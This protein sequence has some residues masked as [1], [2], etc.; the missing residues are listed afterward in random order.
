MYIFEIY[1]ERPLFENPYFDWRHLG[2]ESDMT[3]DQADILCILP[4]KWGEVGWKSNKKGELDLEAEG[5]KDGRGRRINLDYQLKCGIRKPRV[6]MDVELM[7]K[8]WYRAF[9]AMLLPILR[10]QPEKRATAEQV[11]QSE[12]M[13]GWGLPAPYDSQSSSNL[14]SKTEEVSKIG[15]LLAL[16]NNSRMWCG[17]TSNELYRP[18]DPTRS[19]RSILQ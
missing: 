16:E 19:I 6:K 2:R 15:K 18:H 1:G 12:W 5:C 3:E 8:G 7:A 4:R 10:F 17:L 11:L 9:K 13:V 14:I